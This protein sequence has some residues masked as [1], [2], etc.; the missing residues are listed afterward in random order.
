M[1]K[2]NYIEMDF[3]DY[4]GWKEGD[5]I[6]CKIQNGKL[7]VPSAC[8][9]EIDLDSMKPKELQYLISTAHENNWTINQTVEHILEKAV[10]H[11]SNK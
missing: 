8:F 3:A 7:L 2:D 11:F 10:E 4:H 9:V 5:V 6:K 1:N